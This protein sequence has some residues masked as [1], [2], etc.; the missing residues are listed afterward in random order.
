MDNCIE[1]VCGEVG[2]KNKHEDDHVFGRDWTTC[3]EVVDRSRFIF[4]KV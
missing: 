1:V 4:L 3:L 2:S